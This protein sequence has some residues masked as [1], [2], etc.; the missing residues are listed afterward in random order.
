M[1]H[2]QYLRNYISSVSAE[3]KEDEEKKSLLEYL[4]SVPFNPTKDVTK[5]RSSPLHDPGNVVFSPKDATEMTSLSFHKPGNVAFSPQNNM[6]MTASSFYDPKNAI[7]A[8]LLPEDKFPPEPFTSEEWLEFLKKI[9]LVQ[10]VSQDDFLRFAPEVAEEAATMRTE[11]TY[12]KSE[13][14]VYHLLLRPHVVRDIPFVAPHPVRE[15]L[16]KL[17]PPFTKDGQTPFVA[18][19]GAVFREHENIVWTKMSLLPNGQIPGI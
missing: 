15:Q 6:L 10:D 16:Q 8:S 13:R 19:K 18:F 7:F 3:D 12:R 11:N 9:G 17:C 1:A 4:K 2:V 5:K 14:L